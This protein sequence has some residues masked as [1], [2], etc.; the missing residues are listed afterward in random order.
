MKT[1]TLLMLLVVL[2]RAEAQSN[3]QVTLWW[4]ESIV[5]ITPD[6]GFVITTSTNLALPFA[7]WTVITNI[8][9]TN[10]VTT[11]LDSTG[12][13]AVLSF[14]TQIQ[15]GQHFF[16]LQTSNFWGLSLTSNLVSTPA[17]MQP[18]SFDLITRP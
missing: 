9:V 14:H 5:A 16:L 18:N 4:N 12:T 6:A 17:L 11:N 13:N 10:M 15:P 1:L 8:S 3:T 2:L 7:N